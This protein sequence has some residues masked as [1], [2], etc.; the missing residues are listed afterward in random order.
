VNHL[1][2]SKW[3]GDFLIRLAQRF[4]GHPFY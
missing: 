1:E 3:I 2:K 4:S